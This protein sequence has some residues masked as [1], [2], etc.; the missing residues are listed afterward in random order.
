M[1]RAC[2]YTHEKLEI[3]ADSACDVLHAMTLFVLGLKGPM[4]RI[5]LMSF[6][7][8]S[9]SSEVGMTVVCSMR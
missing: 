6:I 1:V 4:Q 5:E 8:S 3:C 9:S 7:S 2:A